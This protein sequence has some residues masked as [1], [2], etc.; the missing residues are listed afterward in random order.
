M[1]ELA[2]HQWSIGDVDGSIAERAS[3]LAEHP[4]DQV[5]RLSLAQAYA[6]TDRLALARSQYEK[7]LELAPESPVVLN[8]YAWTLRD[9]EPARALALAEKARTVAPDFAQ[10]ADTLAVVALRNGDLEQAIK[11][12]DLASARDETDPSIRLHKVLIL[13]AARDLSKARDLLAQ[14]IRDK[15]S[16]PDRSALE[17]AASRL[18]TEAEPSTDSRPPAA[19]D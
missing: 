8:D 13:E 7:A 14:L 11:Y 9:F 2:R 15:P 1:L 19:N 17:A 6:A 10:V 5:A 4:E 16:L 12:S 18:L 3:W